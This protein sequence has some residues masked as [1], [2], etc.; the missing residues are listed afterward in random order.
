MVYELKQ[1]FKLTQKLLLT[2]QLR[3]AI[4]LLQ[5]TRQE[6]LQVVRQ[7]LER[8]P[9]L[10]EEFGGENPEPPAPE[11]G[12]SGLPNE[13]EWQEYIEKTNEGFRPR[14]DLSDDGEESFF[15][16]ASAKGE[17]LKAHLLWQLNCSHLS[18][19][20]KKIGEFIIGNIDEGGYLRVIERG[21]DGEKEYREKTVEE[22]SRLIGVDASEIVTTLEFIHDLDPPGVGART[23]EECL[24]LQAKRFPQRDSIVEGIILNHLESLA[25]KDYRAIARSMGLPVERVIESARV[26]TETLKPVPGSGFG[27]DE[28]RVI[29]PDVYIEKVGGEYIVLLNEDG[30]PKLRISPYYKK[31]LRDNGAG[32]DGARGYIRERFR[33]A[34]WLIK[35]VQQRQR[36]LKRV[37]E[38]I[39]G[40]QKEF[41]DMGLM[42]LRPL[43]LKD[44]ADDIGMHESTVSRV[45]TNKYAE[46]PRGLFDLK[47]FFSNGLAA[48]DGSDV[49]VEYIKEKMRSVIDGEDPRNPLS[50]QQIVERL[51][52]LGIVLARRTVAKYRD[53]FGFLSSTRRKSL[54]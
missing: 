24:F 6:L 36:T 11:N 30:M 44:V 17:S 13:M 47:Y 21:E 34:M 29:M 3:L 33:S 39:V 28:A 40:F 5:L 16:K 26:I 2:P 15:E 48:V 10:E 50:D 12:K 8:N 53:E 43:V 7:E 45:T 31:I 37:V 20:A 54:Y 41:I 14:T 18:E 32:A 19:R 49:T 46:T 23:I 27:A 22:I 42:Y 35:S 51:K 52:G 9:V 38:S 4:K 1:E 25:K